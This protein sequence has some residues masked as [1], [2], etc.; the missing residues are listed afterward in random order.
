MGSGLDVP[1]PPEHAG[2]MRQMA[3]NGAVISEYPL[4]T[5]P[6]ARHFPRRNRLLSGLSLGTLVIEAP[7][8]SGTFSTIR[9][10]LEQN[11]EVLCVPGSI[12]SPASALTNQ[13]IREG[14]KLV[15]NAEDV[16]E[17]L[18]LGAA[19]AHQ[20]PLPGLD[21]P[22]SGDEAAIYEV[23]N[24]DPQHIDDLSRRTEIPVTRVM[25]ALSVMELRG[26]VRQ[27]G[28][29]NFIRARASPAHDTRA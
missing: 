25:G 11:R 15:M 29:M 21:E 20:S 28:R 18:N 14:A 26:Q 16:L 3:E 10:A 7:A 2:L 8:R 22:V 6:D 5:K 23:L 12:Y 4:G 9:S 17:E 27:V 1:Y 13:M 19:T 24:L